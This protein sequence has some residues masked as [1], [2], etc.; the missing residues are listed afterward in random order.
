[1]KLY[2]HTKDHHWFAFSLKTGWVV[3]PAEAGGWENRQPAVG[4]DRLNMREVPLRM[5]FNTGIPGAPTSA[6]GAL[7]RPVAKASRT[8]QHGR[9][10]ARII[11]LTC[12]LKGCVGRCRFQSVDTAPML[13]SA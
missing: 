2:R 10:K 12:N 4:M 7:G 1:M 8:A 9:K 11:C 5:G 13:K 6:A 3:F